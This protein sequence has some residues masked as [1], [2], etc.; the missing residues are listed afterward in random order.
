MKSGIEMVADVARLLKVPKVTG[1]ISGSL[2]QHQRP[3]NSEREDIVVNS[4]ALTG[5][6]LQQGV[7]NVNIHVPN[8]KVNL[9][10]AADNT[11]PDL[12]RMHAIEQVL[13]PLIND[14]DQKSFWIWVDEPGQPYQE[15]ANWYL[16][17]RINYYSY[18]ENYQNV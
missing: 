3:A 14:N 2:W 16:N 5:Q 9:D 7:V 4:L 8:L 17:I 6:Q 13:Y 1:I 12:A 15:G 10:G 11:M 18:Q